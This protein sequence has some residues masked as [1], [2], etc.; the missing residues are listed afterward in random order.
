MAAAP[1]EH[2]VARK[3]VAQLLWRK[4]FADKLLQRHIETNPE[5]PEADMYRQSLYAYA[6]E[7]HNAAEV[8]RRLLYHGVCD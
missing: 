5:R 3:I 2:A 6:A 1:K 8:A 4:R 7:A